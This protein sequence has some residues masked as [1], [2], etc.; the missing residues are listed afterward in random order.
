M[1]FNPVKAVSNFVKKGRRS[2]N[3]LKGEVRGLAPVIGFV[4]GTALG[5]PVGGKIGA[6]V[7]GRLLPPARPPRF[8][9]KRQAKRSRRQAARATPV[10]PPSIQRGRA[11]EILVNALRARA[12]RFQSVPA[13]PPRRS[14]RDV[15][16]L[17]THLGIQ[18][19]PSIAN[20]NQSRQPVYD[21]QDFERSA[22]GVTLL[23]TFVGGG[24]QGASFQ[25]L[26][27]QNRSLRLISVGIG[28]Q[29]GPGNSIWSLI[30]GWRGGTE[31]VVYARVNVETGNVPE[32]LLGAHQEN[33]NDRWSRE[34]PLDVP[35]GGAVTINSGPDFNGGDVVSITVQYEFKP[36]FKEIASEATEWS[37]A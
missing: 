6:S 28:Q 8:K 35:Q 31:S 16:P 10:I 23:K 13:A 2:F 19:S 4:A 18:S 7:A 15:Q 11:L 34:L 1:G 22:R 32:L 25:F 27:P 9:N 3:K 20:V 36:P 37:V 30:V 17:Y 24:G 21:L 33:S 29:S 14:F 5:G 26:V 12:A